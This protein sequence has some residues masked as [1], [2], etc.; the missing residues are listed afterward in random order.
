MGRRVRSST[1]AA[2][3]DAADYLPLYRRYRIQT[4]ALT[5][6]AYAFFYLC[7][8]N[9]SIVK[10]AVAG[11]FGFDNLKLGSIDTAFLSLYAIGQ[12]VNGVV[13][14]RVGG[15]WLVGLG[16]LATAALNL[17]FGFGRDYSLFL[18]VY[19]NAFPFSVDHP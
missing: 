6:L 17:L 4:F 11:D 14:D 15:R 18:A 10:G 2:A 12:F 5:W 7:R 1:P 8:T 3:A 16:L 13:G 9:Y 19:G